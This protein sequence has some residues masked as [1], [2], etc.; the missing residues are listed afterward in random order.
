MK[1]KKH[2]WLSEYKSG[3]KP[4]TGYVCGNC[5]MWNSSSSL[6]CPHCGIRKQITASFKGIKQIA[7][8]RYLLHWMLEHDC[9][10]SD[11]LKALDDLRISSADNSD[12]LP[13]ELFELWQQQQNWLDYDAFLETA[14]KNDLHMQKIL[15]PS[16]YREY[17]AA[18]MFY[19]GKLTKEDLELLEQEGETT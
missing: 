8:N 5:D 3:Y 6:F 19:N 11:I 12:L 2:L 10:L 15:N 13:S 9:D 4:G 16:Q 14:Y 17:C 18:A 1:N 7:Y